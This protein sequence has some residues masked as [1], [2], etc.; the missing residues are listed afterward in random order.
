MFHCSSF[1]AD[2]NNRNAGIAMIMVMRRLI[3]LSIMLYPVRA[4][5]T[6]E[7]NTPTETRASVAACRY[8]ALMFVFL[9]LPFSNKAAVKPLMK[10]AMAD[11]IMTANPLTVVG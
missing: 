4:I 2:N 11:V 8:A 6:P 9:L 1:F 10:I 7:T 3:I 5:S